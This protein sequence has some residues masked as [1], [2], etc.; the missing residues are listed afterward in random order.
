[1]HG[2]MLS[3][4][5]DKLTFFVYFG[6]GDELTLGADGRTAF[7]LDVED[8]ISLLVDSSDGVRQHS[9]SLVSS[10][11]FSSSSILAITR[12]ECS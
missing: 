7:E 6:D 9:R 3:G 11:L 5:V 1:M 8:A 12:Q 4:S 2:G 10:F